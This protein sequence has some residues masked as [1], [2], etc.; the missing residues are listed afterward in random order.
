MIMAVPHFP[1]KPINDLPESFQKTGGL[2][3]II[4][5]AVAV[6]LFFDLKVLLHY[7]QNYWIDTIGPQG[8]SVYGF[9]IQTNN[10]LES[11]HSTLQTMFG[12]HS[13]MW[14]FY[15]KLRCFERKV[16]REFYKPL[17]AN[18]TTLTSRDRNNA[19]I[20]IA[21]QQIVLGRY[22]VFAFL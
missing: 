17:T 15:E 21:I 11:F 12:R 8:F 2:A 4:T 22:D 13:P 1:L 20:D 9:S 3:L 7:I 18:K 19:L 14:P 16:S 10:Y 6:N 5:L